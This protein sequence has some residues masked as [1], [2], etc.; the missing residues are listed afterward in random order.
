MHETIILQGVCN[1][2][3]GAFMENGHAMLTN[4]RFIYSK[5]SFPEGAELSHSQTL[6]IPEGRLPFR[7]FLFLSSG[8]VSCC[9][10]GAVNGL[11]GQ[12]T[13]FWLS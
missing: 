2:I 10:G 8:G 13:L 3:K 6:P 7:D 11:R 4:Q 9:S 1:R 12:G 5:H